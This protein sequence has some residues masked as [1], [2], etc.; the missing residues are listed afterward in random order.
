MRLVMDWVY[1]QN[2][3]CVDC[4]TR[5]ELQAD[6]KKG[7]ERFENPLDADY[8]ENMTLRCRRCNVVR[9]PSHVF[10]GVTFL[11]AEAALMWVLL[12]VRPRTLRD[13][14]RMCRLYGM[15]MSDIRM[16]EAWAMAHWLKRSKPP[17]YEIEDETGLYDV[18]LWGD[19]AVT[20]TQ[21]GKGAPRGARVLRSRARATDVIGFLVNGDRY[22][23]AFEY[24][25]S[26]LPFSTYDLGPR[27]P[28]SLALRYLPPVREEEQA[29][30]ITGLPPRNMELITIGLRAQNEQFIV[31]P[32]PET[33]L[34][35]FPLQA[36]PAF[37]R[38]I[39]IR[40]PLG[41]AML[42]TVPLKRR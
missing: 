14:V 34:K 38:L 32:G 35:E 6:H 25:V 1:A 39:R 27:E 16:Q 19:N 8:I 30:Q 5:L 2:G 42:K 31:V 23:K 21:D 40:K 17:G 24:P 9:R 7:R 18:L 12:V 29:Q 4:G 26:Y 41:K 3:H 15:T 36:I 10:G 20:R 37:G 11:T 28:Q 33:E 22:P 13:F